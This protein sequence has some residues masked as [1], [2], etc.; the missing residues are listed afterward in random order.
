MTCSALPTPQ[1]P[2]L[3]LRSESQEWTL[4]TLGSFNPNKGSTPG[5][6]VCMLLSFWPC[7][8][9]HVYS[10]TANNK[11]PSSEFP[12]VFY[13][14]WPCCV[15]CGILVHRPGIEPGPLAV[16]T[17]TPNHWPTG[18]F[19][20]WW[21]FCWSASRDHRNQKGWSSHSIGP[22]GGLGVDLSNSGYMTPACSDVRKLRTMFRN[23]CVTLHPVS[24]RLTWFLHPRQHLV[25]SQFYLEWVLSVL[26]WVL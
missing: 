13:F 18:E 26:Y 20:L 9:A 6:C 23:G 21:L 16:K 1:F 22:G 14:L 4:E 11:P 3:S 25:L 5:P 2:L 7:W 15:A 24:A 12:V 8:V 10:R 17:W 19:P